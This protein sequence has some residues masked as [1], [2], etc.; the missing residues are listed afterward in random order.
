MWIDREEYEKMAFWGMTI[1]HMAWKLRVCVCAC[2]HTCVQAGLEVGVGT[3][4]RP[5][6]CLVSCSKFG[7]HTS[8]RITEG[9]K[10]TRIMVAFLLRK[11]LCGMEEVKE[12]SQWGG[13]LTET[14]SRVSLGRRGKHLRE[15]QRDAGKLLSLLW[16]EC[17]ILNIRNFNSNMSERLTQVQ[18]STVPFALK[19]QFSQVAGNRAPKSFLIHPQE[20]FIKSTLGIFS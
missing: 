6:T 18:Q 2:T 19:G 3:N 1:I 9:F 8:W 20:D 12:G 4:S 15:K 17:E 7:F 14:G 16:R 5:Q 11:F 13:K 10:Q